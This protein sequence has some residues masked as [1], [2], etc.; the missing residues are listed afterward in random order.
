MGKTIYFAK[1]NI[2]DDKVFK[3]YDGSITVKDIM[4]KLSVAISN[5]ISY[6]RLINY[7]I[8]GEE[9]VEEQD[10]AFT[11]IN[12]LEEEVSDVL[13]GGVIKTS[14]I[15]RNKVDNK[16]GDKTTTAVDND[17]IIQFCFYPEKEIVAFDSTKRFGYQT[18]CRAFEG[19]LSKA[20]MLNDED[21]TCFKVSLL[22]K[23]VSLDNIKNE[24]R[25]IKNIETIKIDIIPPNPNQDILDAIKKNAEKQLK[26]MEEGR[27]TEKSIVFK[28]RDKR[29][30]NPESEEIV[31]ELNN[32]SA[33]HSKLEVEDSIANGYVEVEAKS[34]DGSI[35][36][37]N[38]SKIIKH[39]LPRGVVGDKLF[40]D[41][42]R[43]KIISLVK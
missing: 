5:G 14:K 38:D 8:D 39:R 13:V 37:T 7:T 25:K 32:I 29:G 19:L 3:L 27:I 2:N 16:T 40:A 10:F 42:C 9:Q 20:S 31:N 4:T 21:N 6:K 43:D 22:T 34:S 12:K 17:E 24:L 33:I 1:I 15:Y 28:S 18:F 26:N 41:Y 35:Y 36:N 30:L 11:A 23:G